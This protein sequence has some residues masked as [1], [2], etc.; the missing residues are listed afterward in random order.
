M[1]RLG[2]LLKKQRESQNLSESE[3][4][5]LSGISLQWIQEIENSEVLPSKIQIE[6]LAAVPKLGLGYD[7]LH[8]WK[9]QELQECQQLLNKTI[10][11]SEKWQCPY[12]RW[13]CPACMESNEA[14]TIECDFLKRYIGS[15]EEQ[16][17][18]VVPHLSSK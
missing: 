1:I 12:R 5:N 16:P 15:S 18:G 8:Q 17:I 6:K 9:T 10:S 13:S 2:E 7:T 14:T 3:L 11:K 4:A